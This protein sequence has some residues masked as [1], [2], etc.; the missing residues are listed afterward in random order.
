MN[1]DWRGPLA[2]PRD[3]MDSIIVTDS[4]S[5]SINYKAFNQMQKKM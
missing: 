2:I 1:I 3:P 4:S 5:M